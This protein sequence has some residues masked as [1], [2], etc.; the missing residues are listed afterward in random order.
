MPPAK[1]FI[2]TPRMQRTLRFISGFALKYGR[3]PSGAEVAVGVE[4]SD[5]ALAV[6]LRRMLA[7]ELIHRRAA[8]SSKNR[9]MWR[10]TVRA[11]GKEW[12]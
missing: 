4:M 7:I 12:L 3:G 11:R 6:H 8:T 10:Y 9:P 1:E 2:F 5:S